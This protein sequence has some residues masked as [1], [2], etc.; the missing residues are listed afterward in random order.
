MP[1]QLRDNPIFL[2]PIDAGQLAEFQ[3]W[4]RL[5]TQRMIARYHLIPSEIVFDIH[6]SDILAKDPDFAIHLTNNKS[7]LVHA[8]TGER[9]EIHLRD[10]HRVE[11]LM[12]AINGTSSFGEL[13]DD[14]PGSQQEVSSLCR[15]LLGSV[16]TLPRTIQELQRKVPMVELVRFPQQSPYC[17]PR[18]YW[19]NSI[20]IRDGLG[21]LYGSAGSHTDFLEALSGFHRIATLGESGRNYYGGGGGVATVPG[22]FRELEMFTVVGRPILRTVEKWLA[23]L[24]IPDRLVR[25]GVI[26]SRD[27]RAMVQ[28]HDEG[29]RCVHTCRT[30]GSSLLALLDEA[31]D[32]LLNALQARAAVD[33]GTMIGACAR[34]HQLIVTAHPF[35]NIN[36]SIA[37]NVVNDLLTKEHLGSLSHLYLDYLAQRTTPDDYASAFNTAVEKYAI[38]FDDEG[39]INRGMQGSSALLRIASLQT[40]AEFRNLKSRAAPQG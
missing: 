23:E 4:E 40:V 28:I 29:L 6:T 30:D 19:E 37:M 2:N 3:N 27:K 34:F 17:L 20:A 38:H 10:A 33:I 11:E 5:A 13:L 26:L 8:R 15:H 39:S 24:S 25:S 18:P 21:L 31:R 1:C 9:I 7:V 14:F 35:N 16:I 12:N 22:G 36:N 32:E